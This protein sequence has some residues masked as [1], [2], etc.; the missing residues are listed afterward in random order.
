LEVV[1]QLG[2]EGSSMLLDELT[3]DKWEV[4]VFV[5]SLAC[6]AKLLLILIFLLDLAI[7]IYEITIN[8]L[9]TGCLSIMF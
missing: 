8:C 6:L 1:F 4:T 7:I 5:S 9:F 2:A 3:R